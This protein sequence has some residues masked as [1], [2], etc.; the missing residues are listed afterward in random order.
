MKFFKQ[1]ELEQALKLFF[2]GFEKLR[3]VWQSDV[4]NGSTITFDEFC[5]KG[6]AEFEENGKAYVKKLMSSK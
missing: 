1:F 6:K 4:E 5:A 2:N 3:E